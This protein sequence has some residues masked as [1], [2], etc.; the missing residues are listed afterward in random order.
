M[1]KINR[2]AITKSAL[3]VAFVVGAIGGIIGDIIVIV[4]SGIMLAFVLLLSIRASS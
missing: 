1:K 2:K 3:I 4:V